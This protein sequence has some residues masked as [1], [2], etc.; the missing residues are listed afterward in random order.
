MNVITVTV[1]A[2]DKSTQTYTVTVTVRS[3]ETL[4]QRYDENRNGRIDEAEA[5]T[6]VDDYLFNDTLTR[7]Q[8]L[9]VINLYLFG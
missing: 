2:E 8:A 6:A 3:G 1:R 9:D 4:L 5:R 7:E